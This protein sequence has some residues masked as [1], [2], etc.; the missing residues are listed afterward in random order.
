MFSVLKSRAWFFLALASILTVPLASAESLWE[1]RGDT[2]YRAKRYQ[3]ALLAYQTALLQDTDNP[4]LIEKYEKAALE[5]FAMGK[6]PVGSRPQVPF[7]Q[8][9]VRR[10]P[11]EAAE[12]VEAS[13][14]AGAPEGTPSGADPH[15]GQP[16]G[17]AKDSPPDSPKV[18]PASGRFRSMGRD[19]SERGR[20]R[21]W[22]P[23]RPSA[24][25]LAPP[26]KSAKLP[27]EPEEDPSGAN[28]ADP[29]AAESKAHSLVQEAK[30]GAESA[31][32]EG[33]EDEEL[34]D[35][36]K[37]L[38]TAKDLE[39]IL[40][41]VNRLGG[42]SSSRDSESSSGSNSGNQASSEAPEDKGPVTF[43]GSQIV[44]T[45]HLKTGYEGADGEEVE[46]ENVEIRLPKYKITK[47]KLSYSTGRNLRIRGKIT[48]LTQTRVL[49]PKVYCKVFDEDGV[50]RG[51]ASGNI[52]P[53]PN[54]FPAGKTRS[55]D[56]LLRGYTGT[57]SS[58]QFEV[59]P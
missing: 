38:V 51:A 6:G 2:H 10:P 33:E 27:S 18:R 50:L 57:V 46:A 23:R 7:N 19:R 4:R 22:K 14:S 8:M 12:E 26:A 15:S 59:F 48:N 54:V 1:T 3:R 35:L 42:T 25:S 24:D 30:G 36:S 37:R 32:S 34:P 21:S 28:P 17:G 13:A 45:D 5:V 29:W 31:R 11:P 47:V 49:R 9:G 44:R 55:F 16:E 58:Y 41:R 52:S 39:R 53:G 20:F 43:G 40:S 56:L